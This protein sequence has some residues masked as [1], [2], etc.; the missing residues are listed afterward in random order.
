MRIF[1][2]S[3]VLQGSPARTLV[4]EAELS[5]FGFFQRSSIQEFLT[6]FTT[7]IAERTQPGDR[8]CIEEQQNIGYAHARLE[9]LTGVLI[10]DAEYPMRTA[11]SVLNKILDDFVAKVPKS[12]WDSLA[13]SQT[14]QIFPELRDYL[15]QFQDPHAADPYLKVQKELDETKVILHKTMESL[16]QRG[17]KLDD[18][19]ARSDALSAQSKLF[20]KTAKKTNS[21]CYLS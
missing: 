7:T 3:I 5:A 21:C 19:V 15:A 12:R 20:Y 18:L 9:G 8:Q 4:S 10:A 13:P 6:F 1:S 2:I 17:E 16:L 14:A 11:F